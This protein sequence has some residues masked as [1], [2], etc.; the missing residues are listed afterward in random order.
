MIK[1]I[2]LGEEL[3][4]TGRNKPGL[5]AD[6]SIILANSGI[7]IEAACGFPEG[8]K[9]K[10]MLITSANLGVL[11]ELRKHGYENVKETEVLLIDLKNKT[12]ALKI[13][14]TELASKGINIRYLYVTTCSCGNASRMV[15]STS[16]NET[17]MSVLSKFL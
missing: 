13:V 8:R 14:A 12:G 1:N 11:Y 9:A 2:T 17:A 7:N 3:V 5:L 4:I 15:L 6:I 16:D 10:V